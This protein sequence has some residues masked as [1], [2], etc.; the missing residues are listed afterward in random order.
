MQL[1]LS[2]T[3]NALRMLFSASPLCCWRYIYPAFGSQVETLQ[4]LSS[5]TCIELGLA[6]T[7]VLVQPLLHEVGK[8]DIVLV[9][10]ELCNQTCSMPE[11]RRIRSDWQTRVCT[12]YLIG[13][14]VVGST[15]RRHGVPRILPVLDRTLRRISSKSMWKQNGGA[16]SSRLSRSCYC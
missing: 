13:A 1:N 8:Y 4:H 14:A 7:K 5:K 9:T 10:V 16:S 3:W 15:A 2:T 12:I 11:R 6:S